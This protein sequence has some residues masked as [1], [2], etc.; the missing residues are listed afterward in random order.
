MKIGVKI[1]DEEEFVEYFQDKAD[2]I[3]VMA[4]EGKNYDFLKKYKIPYIIHAQHAGFRVNFADKTKNKKN[5]SSI[6]FAIKLA[7]KIGAKKIIQHPGNLY[8]KSCSKENALNLLK[9]I[10]DK[11]IIIENVARDGKRLC[12][13]PEQTKE[14]LKKSKQGF[15]FDLAHCYINA[16]ILKKDPIKLIKQFL[17]LKPSHFHISGQNSKSKKDQHLSFKSKKANLPLKKILKLYPKNA[18]I[19]LE[20]EPNIKKIKHDINYIKN[21]IKQ[22]S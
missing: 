8:N 21:I 20:T 15:L 16:T 10:K 1:F 14:F 3:E 6:N 22:I 18:W 2:F 5:L 19:T 13:T 7:N 4:I 12:T 17:K 11:R 9:R